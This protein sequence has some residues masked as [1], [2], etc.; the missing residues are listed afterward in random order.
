MRISGS[1]V[2]RA[3][4][5]TVWAS[6]G[7]R[8]VLLRAVPG[9][10]RLGATGNGRYQ[11]MLT[12]PIAAV[13]GTYSVVAELTHADPVRGLGATVLATGAKG[14]VDARVTVGLS[15]G[16]G[17]GTRVSYEADAEVTG[18]VAGIG[19]RL[20]ASVAERLAAE[21]LAGLDQ[22]LSAQP[23]AGQP[24]RQPAGPAVERVD[25]PAVRREQPGSA[26]R[27]GMLAGAAAG[28]GGVLIG[29]LLGRRSRSQLP[30]RR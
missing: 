3:P 14:S 30:G 18:P 12:I 24:P 17:E 29:L 28:F 16:S 15:A 20:L 25:Q 8:D 7:D 11:F 4:A 23:A 9:L 6:L 13:S 5:E 22:V 1:G 19:Q 2:V 27:T 21:F 10:E 26:V